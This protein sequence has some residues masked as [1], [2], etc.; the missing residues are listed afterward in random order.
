VRAE[1]LNGWT[2]EIAEV[3]EVAEETELHSISAVG[4]RLWF[5]SAPSLFSSA[6]SAVHKEGSA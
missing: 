2:A 5:L 4:V 1:I 6:L 3:A